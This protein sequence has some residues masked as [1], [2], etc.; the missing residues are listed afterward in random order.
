MANR[1]FEMYELR[2]ILVR[3]RLGDPD[4]AIARSG[5]MGRRKAGELRERALAEGWLDLSTAL[6]ED[7]A[8]AEPRT[9]SG[10]PRPRFNMD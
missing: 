5:L 3:M 4:R 7:A 8:L 2:R 1:R 9:T 10:S 6:P